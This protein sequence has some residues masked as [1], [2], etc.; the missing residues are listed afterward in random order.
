[1]TMAAEGTDDG[2]TARVA[3]WSYGW[4]VLVGALLGFG[5]ASI[6]TIGV[7]LLAMAAVLVVIG[8]LAPALRTRAARATVGG[9]ALAPLYLAWLNRDGPGEVCRTTATSVSCAEQ[10]SPWPVL[11]VGLALVVVAVLWVRRR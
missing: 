5:V 9:L 3:P 1:M 10:W 7:V 8:V 6:P 4:W 2:S 11:V